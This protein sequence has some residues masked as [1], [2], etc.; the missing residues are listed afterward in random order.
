MKLLFVSTIPLLLN[1]SILPPASNAVQE[2]VSDPIVLEKRGIFNGWMRPFRRQATQGQTSAEQVHPGQLRSQDN[3]VIDL[4]Q[5]IQ[6]QNL[7]RIKELVKSN[8]ISITRDHLV[9]AKEILETAIPKTK[10]ISQKILKYLE[11]EEH[12]IWKQNYVIWSKKQEMLK[13]AKKAKLSP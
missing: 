8:Q 3:S 4:T 11:K 7:P 13:K 12:R 9:Q 1:A 10:R 2:S 5:E 6:N